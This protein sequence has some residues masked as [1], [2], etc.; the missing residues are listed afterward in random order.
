MHPSKSYTFT[1]YESALHRLL[2]NSSDELRHLLFTSEPDLLKLLKFLL[3]CTEAPQE[4][5]GSSLLKGLHRWADSKEITWKS[6]NKWCEYAVPSLHVPFRV[7][8]RKWVFNTESPPLTSVDFGEEARRCLHVSGEVFNG[9]WSELFNSGVDGLSFEGL[10]HA[11][12]GYGGATLIVV[13]DTLGNVFG[14]F[15]DEEW[16]ENGNFYGSKNNVLY[17]LSPEFAVFHTR[18]HHVSGAEDTE[19]YQYLNTKSR[20]SIHG[21]GF[22]GS[23][24]SMRLWISGTLEECSA[25]SIGLTYE[26]GAL[27]GVKKGDEIGTVCNPDNFDVAKLQLFGFG[28]DDAIKKQ[29]LVREEKAELV[30]SRRQ[31]DKKQF[32]QGEFDREFLLGGVFK[33][34]NQKQER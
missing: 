24:E 16:K 21:I 5:D 31:V 4:V 12:I 11:M 27:R 1:D 18:E 28:G 9:V 17:A 3:N 25:R 34:S 23:K 19:N 20:S 10:S 22:G 14:A 30:H 8:L 13:T 6:F 32:V 29:D 2:H 26:K 7:H 15:S 33:A